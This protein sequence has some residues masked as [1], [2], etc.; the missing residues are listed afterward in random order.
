MK[1]FTYFNN[2]GSLNFSKKLVHRAHDQVL[3]SRKPDK[4]KIADLHARGFNNIDF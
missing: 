1:I 4:A 3:I 2:A